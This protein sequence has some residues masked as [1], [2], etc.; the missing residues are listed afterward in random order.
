MVG[1]PRFPSDWDVT[2]TENHWYMRYI[3]KV[4]VPYVNKVRETL[5][6][7]DHAALAIFDCFWGQL[8]KLH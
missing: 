7:E 4:I 5:Q 1:K 6:L 8:T 3:D 2:H